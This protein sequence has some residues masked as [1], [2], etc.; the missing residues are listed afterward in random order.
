MKGKDKDNVII[1]HCPYKEKFID[2]LMAWLKKLKNKTITS[3]ITYSWYIYFVLF[4]LFQNCT[5]LNNIEFLRQEINK[6]LNP[7]DQPKDNED[8]RFSV[9]SKTLSE[10]EGS[11]LC[12]LDGAIRK[13]SSLLNI[14]YRL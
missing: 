12:I 2:I 8:D 4:Y 5:I 3:G 9:A 6:L 13:V 1:S 14:V 11:I 7:C 10:M